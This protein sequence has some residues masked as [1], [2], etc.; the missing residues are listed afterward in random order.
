MNKAEVK[1]LG[2]PDEVREFPKGDWS[3]SRSATRRL[4]VAPSSRVGRA[5]SFNRSRK[6]RVA[7]LHTFI[8]R[9][10]N[11]EVRMDDGTDLSA[12]LETSHCSPRDTTHGLSGRAG[13]S[14]RFQGMIDYAKSK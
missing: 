4:V 10:G 13:S 1:H 2:K 5:T 8:S 9:F 12:G 11:P 3:S 7:R 14:R 6:P